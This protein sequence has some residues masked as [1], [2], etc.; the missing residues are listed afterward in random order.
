MKCDRCDN[1]ANFFY[2]AFINGQTAELH[3]CVDCAQEAGLLQPVNTGSPFV[4]FFD[5]FFGPSFGGQRPFSALSGN[6]PGG[7]V[8]AGPLPAEKGAENIPADA[9]TAV[10]R[11]R[12]Q[13]TLRHQ[14]S[15]AVQAEDFEKAIELRDK[16]KALECK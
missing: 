1:E 9:G 3:L 4:G 5:S 14:L 10:R 12:E 6:A 7:P 16:L 13:N 15:V 2:R 8:E 11:Q